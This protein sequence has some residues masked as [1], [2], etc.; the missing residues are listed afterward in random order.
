MS[1]AKH[2]WL[3]FLNAANPLPESEAAERLRSSRSWVRFSPKAELSVLSHPCCQHAPSAAQQGRGWRV[4]GGPT[5]NCS[6]TPTGNTVQ[7]KPA[8]EQALGSKHLADWP[9]RSDSQY[10]PGQVPLQIIDFKD[11]HPCSLSPFPDLKNA[12]VN[13]SEYRMVQSR[14]QASH[15]PSTKCGSV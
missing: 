15:I 1:P 4:A 10:N 12:H 11:C 7:L 5:G 3:D 2:Y 13:N 14:S 9:S 8:T 6:Q